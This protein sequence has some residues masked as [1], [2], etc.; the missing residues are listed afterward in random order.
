MIMDM[1]TTA[2]VLVEEIMVEDII[3]ADSVEE[4]DIIGVEDI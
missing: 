1:E 3:G 2:G 4:D